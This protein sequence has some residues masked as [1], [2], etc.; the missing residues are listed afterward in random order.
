[1]EGVVLRKGDDLEHLAHATEDL[2]KANL[3]VV[4][5]YCL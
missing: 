1:L 5:F 3:L 2:E 4:T